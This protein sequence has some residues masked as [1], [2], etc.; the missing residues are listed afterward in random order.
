MWYG[1]REAQNK[2]TDK[3]AILESFIDDGVILCCREIQK[4][5]ADSLY[6]AIVNFI[7]DNKIDHLFKITLGEIV[8]LQTNSR[9]ILLA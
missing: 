2:R 8:N 6:S 5:I 9:F 4:S 3:I 7:S 1:G